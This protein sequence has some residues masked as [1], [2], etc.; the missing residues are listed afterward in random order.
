MDERRWTDRPLAPGESIETPGCV[1]TR[2]EPGVLNLVSG[3][4]D[5]ALGILAPNA[6]RLGFAET[7]GTSDFALRIGRDHALLVTSKA[8]RLAPGWHEQGFS[9]S[10]AGDFYACLTLVGPSAP[11]LLAHGLAAPPPWGSPSAAVQFCGVRSF[12]SG[13]PGGLALWLEAGFLTYCSSF[14]ARCT[15]E[16]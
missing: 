9:L 5:A 11:D 3:N 1:V 10:A 12:V 6:A 8:P 2:R 16:P 4:L 7:P 14:L 13:V 15:Q